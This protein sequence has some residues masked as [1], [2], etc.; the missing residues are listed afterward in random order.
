MTH[1]ISNCGSKA[2][3]QVL[4]S[5]V[6]TLT[7]WLGGYGA[8]T[9]LRNKDIFK[10]SNT[11]GCLPNTS[12]LWDWNGMGSGLSGYSSKVLD[13][14]LGGIVI[15]F[16]GGL[17]C[18]R[19]HSWLHS[20]FHFGLNNISQYTFTGRTSCLSRL[21][22]SSKN[23]DEVDQEKKSM[24]KII[25][26]AESLHLEN[27]YASDDD[28]TDEHADNE[29][30]DDISSDSDVSALYTAR[31]SAHHT[32]NDDCG[33]TITAP[34]VTMCRLQRQRSP[35]LLEVFPILYNMDIDLD[36]CESQDFSQ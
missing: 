7:G 19:L 23:T 36:G 8:H 33:K 25:E 9:L 28:V 18:Y 29:D 30:A 10:H 16:A 20:N 34:Q 27:Y 1:K 32:M 12:N 26:F 31:C 2:F 3:E 14:F 22:Y 6:W 11:L 24:K 17:G 4:G 15:T 35:Y 21:F 5:G 13:R